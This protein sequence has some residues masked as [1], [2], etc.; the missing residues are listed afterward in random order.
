MNY[1]YHLIV[2][3]AGSAGL[4]VASAAAGLGAKVA[5][6]EKHKMGGDCLNTGCIPS[7]TFLK[8]AHLAKDIL[9]ADGY[10]L[11]AKLGKVDLEKVMARVKRVIAEIAPHDSIER[12]ESLGVQVFSGHAF[13]ID[14]HTIEVGGQ[15][16]T[17]KSIVITTG[18][19]PFIP[20]IKGL[21]TVPYLT[22]E[23][24]FDLKI[25]PER[26]IVLGAGPIGLELGQGF[27]HLG[28]KV[29]VID[30]DAKLF[31]K[32]DPEVSSV[33]ETALTQ[34]G[35]DF[36]LSSTIMQIKSVANGILVTIRQGD[37]ITEILGDTLL[38][39]LGR[40]PATQGLG[41]EKIGLVTDARGFITTNNQLQTSVRH[42]Y[43][44]GDVVGPYLFTH[45]AGYQARIVVQNAALGLW[46]KVDYS[47]VAWTTYTKP[48][49]AHVGYT[50]S[51]AHARGLFK[52][53]III[54]LADI[55]RAKTE[56]DR[57]GFLKLI[58]DHQG[59]IIGATLVSEKAGEMISLATLAIEKKCK[60]AVFLKI[61]FAYPAESEI[62]LF[63]AFSILK[64]NFKKWQKNLLKFIF[65]R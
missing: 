47:K 28:S 55:D 15:M 61:L 24:I 35:M 63:A 52:N 13:F 57:Y 20:A 22:N 29:S 59:K 1:D 9:S 19:S 17:A 18:S 45:M 32:D 26:L 44:C 21:D 46:K 34:D 48:E 31:A 7:K 12:Y 11:S 58:L 49:V 53:A 60:P 2:I 36:H 14:T 10:G 27:C 51:I 41:L 43:A 23:T 50:E 25:L 30:Q 40:K 5:L 65:F 62:F 37:I 4:V 38:L 33:M 54:N 64:T 16:L 39:A 42:I 3:G 6:I 8:S 56:N